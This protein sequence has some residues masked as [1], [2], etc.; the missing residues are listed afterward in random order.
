[1][2]RNGQKP[3]NDLK[4]EITRRGLLY[5]QVAQHADVDVTQGHLSDILNG[6][7]PLSR[8]LE[9]GIRRA[10]EELSRDLSEVGS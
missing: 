9:R 3:R 4:A 1:M 5:K 10:I 7:K 2:T 6:R 8:R